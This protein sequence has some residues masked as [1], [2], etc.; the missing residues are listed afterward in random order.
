MRHLHPYCQT[1]GDSELLDPKNREWRTA[2][3]R[4]MQYKVCYKL[5]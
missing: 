4:A 2:A 5:R 3:Q 1:A